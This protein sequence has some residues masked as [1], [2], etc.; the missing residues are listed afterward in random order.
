MQL[1]AS[2]LSEWRKKHPDLTMLSKL[3]SGKE[4]DLWLVRI[5]SELRAL[6]VY[7]RGSLSTR[8]QYNAGQWISEASLRKAVRQKTKVGKNLQA[9]LWT[10]REFYLLK[11]LREQ[12]AIVPQALDYTSNAILMEYLGAETSPAPRLI[13]V[14]LDPA[15]IARVQ[16]Q[17]EQ[18]IKLFLDDGIVH[19]DLS[20]YNIL[21]W[22]GKPWI[23]DFPQAADIR[24]NP[25]WRELYD[26]DIR[27]V[28]DYFEAATRRS[29]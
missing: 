17:I 21:W 28:R 10:K 23:I 14:R 24:R 16:V 4:A 20:A 15:I 19:G 9:R 6:K 29:S 8:G 7:A 1:D 2:V 25:N 27:N 26:R 3:K 11:K 18:S 12:G 22:D 13:D 5:D